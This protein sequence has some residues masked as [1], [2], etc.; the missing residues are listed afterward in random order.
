MPTQYPLWAIVVAFLVP[1][2]VEAVRKLLPVIGAFLAKRR[3][4]RL[5]AKAEADVAAT[6]LIASLRTDFEEERKRRID[7]ENREAEL[8]RKVG[9]LE[10]QLTRAKA[11]LEEQDKRIKALETALGVLK[12]GTPADG[13]LRPTASGESDT[14]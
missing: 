11:R 12:E 14:L 7:A 5:A 3:A 4:A 9:D 2:L 6:G 13:T 8:G 10:A 1:I